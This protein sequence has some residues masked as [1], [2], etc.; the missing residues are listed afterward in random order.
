MALPK[1][2]SSNNKVR[3]CITITASVCQSVCEDFDQTYE[4]LTCTDEHDGR[5]GNNLY[6]AK[7]TGR[8]LIVYILMGMVC[9]RETTDRLHSH[10]HGVQRG[11]DL[12]AYE[13]G[14]A[15]GDRPSGSKLRH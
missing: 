10:G 1:L 5:K 14:V 2:P 6:R 15:K 4:L 11:Q 8:R 12:H 7:L 13:C 3:E 9:R